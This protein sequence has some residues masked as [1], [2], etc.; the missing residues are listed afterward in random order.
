MFGEFKDKREYREYIIK[1]GNKAVSEAQKN[2]LEN[3]VPNVYWKNGTLYYQLPNGD[4]TMEDPF[5]D[6]TPPQKNP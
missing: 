5:K 4:I 3:G 1:I 6:D 2:N